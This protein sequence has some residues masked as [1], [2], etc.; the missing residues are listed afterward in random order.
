MPLARGLFM[1]NAR[2]VEVLLPGIRKAEGQGMHREVWLEETHCKTAGRRTG[3][4]SEVWYIRDELARDNEV[5]HL[6]LGCAL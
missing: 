5:L 4:P 3:T 6:R 2:E 1:A